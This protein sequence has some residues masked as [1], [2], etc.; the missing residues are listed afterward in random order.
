MYWLI[1]WWSTSWHYSVDDY[2]VG[3]C[4][5]IYSVVKN[6][7]TV[8]IC[9]PV[10]LTQIH[11]HTYTH[12]QAHI[13]THKHTYTHTQAHIHTHTP[14]IAMSYNAMHCMSPK[15][16]NCLLIHII[17]LYCK[18][19]NWAMY[20]WFIS[21]FFLSDAHINS[22][23]GDFSE[24]SLPD[25]I[26]KRIKV[27]PLHA[28]TRAAIGK[29]HKDDCA[30]ENLVHW[31]RIRA[32]ISIIISKRRRLSI[33][34]TS[35]FLAGPKRGVCTYE[36]LYERT[37]CRHL[38][39][40]NGIGKLYNSFSALT[41]PAMKFETEIVSPEGAVLNAVRIIVEQLVELLLNLTRLT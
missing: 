20:G 17:G 31:R 40:H 27:T 33:N 4:C 18:C 19:W 37:A 26:R 15:N 36:C 32:Q 3:F 30:R 13:H 8:S 23:G 21:D 28:R 14:T 6:G 7:G 41:T 11:K 38:Q 2:V 1:D 35:G 29:I 25:N 9:F 12:T 34:L 16:G 39:L 22:H 10:V 5:T 24:C